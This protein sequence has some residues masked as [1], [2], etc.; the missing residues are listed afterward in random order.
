MCQ[1]LH[2]VAGAWRCKLLSRFVFHSLHVGGHFICAD[3]NN[4]KI[5]GEVKIPSVK[6]LKINFKTPI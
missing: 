3:A 5:A 6:T 1:R 2:V 4:I